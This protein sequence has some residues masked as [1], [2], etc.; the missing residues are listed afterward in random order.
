MS[1]VVFE[2][3]LE[4]IVV[5]DICK[6]RLGKPA[7]EVTINMLESMKKDKTAFLSIM[8]EAE[9]YNDKFM[10]EIE[11]QNGYQTVIINLI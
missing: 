7:Y 8:V 11:D 1:K 5:T 6:M 2:E 9:F 10:L 3:L 4:D